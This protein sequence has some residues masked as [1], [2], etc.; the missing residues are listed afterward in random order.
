MAT[1]TSETNEPVQ[2][3]SLNLIPG[4]LSELS[5]RATHLIVTL[6][7]DSSSANAQT[8][9]GTVPSSHV[10]LEGKSLVIFA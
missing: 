9:C 2:S 8:V 4:M 6:V 5:K 10:D 3:E 1:F 7:D